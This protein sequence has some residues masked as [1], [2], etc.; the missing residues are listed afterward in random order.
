MSGANSPA[1]L[2]G[3]TMLFYDRTNPDTYGELVS[4]EG[5]KNAFEYMTNGVGMH[6]G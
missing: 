1:F 5:N 6:P 4:W 2:T 3:Y